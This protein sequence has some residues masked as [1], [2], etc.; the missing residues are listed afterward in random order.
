MS[1]H[2]LSM[3][4]E[5]RLC[6]VFKIIF[7]IYLYIYNYY[8]FNPQVPVS[9]DNLFT[10]LQLLNCPRCMHVSNYTAR[11]LL[12]LIYNS[13]AT[14]CIGSSTRTRTTM[15]GGFE[16][17]LQCILVLPRYKFGVYNPL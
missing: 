11:Y 4:I 14:H 9:V 5:C 17:N 10:P 13:L 15:W 6:K 7:C 8:L 16:A 3:Y 1:V 12:L 2:L